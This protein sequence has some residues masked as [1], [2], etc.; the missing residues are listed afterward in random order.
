EE[1]D[2][3]EITHYKDLQI[4][5]DGIGVNNPAF[6]VTPNDLVTAI[7]TEKGVARFPYTESLKKQ[8]EE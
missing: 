3:R 5:P 6:D 8:F 1:R 4:A 2:R 7:I